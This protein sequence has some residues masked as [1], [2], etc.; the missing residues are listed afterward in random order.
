MN[1]FEQ[2]SQSYQ[3]QIVASSLEALREVLAVAG[4]LSDLD[5]MVIADGVVLR[6]G[7]VSKSSGFEGTQFVFEAVVTMLTTVGSGVLTAWLTDKLKRHPK[8]TATVDGEQLPVPPS[9]GSAVPP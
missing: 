6:D 8:V 1:A 4:D 3:V 5:D 7:Q 9:A 2:E